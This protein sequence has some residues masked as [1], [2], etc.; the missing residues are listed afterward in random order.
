MYVLEKLHNCMFFD[1]EIQTS[2][3]FPSLHDAMLHILD[4]KRVYQRN[5]GV[6]RKL[7]MCKNQ[8]PNNK[9]FVIVS[10]KGFG[11]LLKVLFLCGWVLCFCR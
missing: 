7:E 6:V 8:F 1:D 11:N 9:Y 2:I 10:N 5:Y 3:F 4:K